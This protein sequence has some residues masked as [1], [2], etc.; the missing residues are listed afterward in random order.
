[1]NLMLHIVAKDLRRLRWQLAIWLGL[2]V[3]KYTI[4]FTLIWGGSFSLDTFRR[5][6]LVTMAMSVAE[7]AL[8]FLLTALL[9]QGD[10]VGGTQQ[11]WLTRPISGGRMPRDNAPLP[12]RLQP[13]QAVSR[14]C[15]N[16][17]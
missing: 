7:V 5:L 2:L 14:K 10:R 17:G 6:E 16:A 13:A 4:G 3:A 15:G 1:M 12:P 11:F 8:V 9:V